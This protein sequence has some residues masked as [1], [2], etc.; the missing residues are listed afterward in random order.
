MYGLHDLWKQ[1]RSIY[2]MDQ[3]RFR[4]TVH[5]SIL[6]DRP[7]QLN[8]VPMY[9]NMNRAIEKR[10]NLPIQLHVDVESGHNWR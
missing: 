3:V 9:N 5:D 2:R 7:D 8:L 6:I 4:L 1:V 10:Y